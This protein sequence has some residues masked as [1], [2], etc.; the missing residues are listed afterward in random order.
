MFRRHAKALPILA[1]AALGTVLLACSG[2]SADATRATTIEGL[3]GDT[4]NGKTLYDATCT[5]CHGADGKSGSEK[6]N[7]A[8]NSS[9]NKSGAVEQVLGGGGSMPAYADQFTD[10]EIADIVAY[11][12]SLK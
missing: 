7:V 8:S 5:A 3:T 9:S 2:S 4:A 6:R 12:A 1:I 11:T 10:Q